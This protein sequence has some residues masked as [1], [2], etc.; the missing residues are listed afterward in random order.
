MCGRAN[1]VDAENCVRCGRAKS[2]VLAKFSSR[3]ALRETIVKAQEEAEKQ[4]LEEEERLKAEKEY[5]L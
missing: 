4:R 1:F 5:T 2:D 3:D